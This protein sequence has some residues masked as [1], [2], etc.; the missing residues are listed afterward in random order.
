ETQRH[1]RA[2]QLCPDPR[3]PPHLR[4]GQRRPE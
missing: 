2:D 3:R 1:L 4:G